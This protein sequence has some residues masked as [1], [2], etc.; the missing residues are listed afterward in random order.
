MYILGISS[1]LVSLNMS[2]TVLKV[3]QK[4]DGNIRNLV[5][6]NGKLYLSGDFMNPEDG[7]R[8]LMVVS[9]FW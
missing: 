6:K 2:N 7:I 4:F 3:I 5:Y 9:E 1:L 8:S